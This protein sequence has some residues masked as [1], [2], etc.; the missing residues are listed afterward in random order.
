MIRRGPWKFI[1]SEP[2]PPLLFDL[3]RD[4]D[5]LQNL[6]AAPQHAATAEEFEA[7]V[8]R[9]W[10]PARLHEQILRSQRARRL[11]F[12]ALSRGRHTPWDFQPSLHL[13]RTGG[14]PLDLNELERRR[15][16]PPVP[17]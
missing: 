4:P 8:H 1:W 11:A 7:E 3:E 15:R 17:G 10:E 2:D 16:F 9:L 13:K 12:D 5:E 14:D 6:A